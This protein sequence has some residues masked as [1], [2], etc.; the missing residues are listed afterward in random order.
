MGFPLGSPFGFSLGPSVVIPL[1]ET[2]AQPKFTTDEWVI[3]QGMT[4][5]QLATAATQ[6]AVS[7][8]SPG[9]PPSS[10]PAFVSLEPAPTMHLRL[11]TA[12]SVPV[13]RM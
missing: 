2:L 4:A 6:P 8:I 3:L 5:N 13:D 1:L 9:A 10:R 7:S 11:P 12:P